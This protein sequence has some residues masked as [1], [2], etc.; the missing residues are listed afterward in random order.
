MSSTSSSRCSRRRACPSRRRRRSRA[1]PVQ[2]RREALAVV[3]SER[4][5]QRPVLL[6]CRSPMRPPEEAML[7]ARERRGVT[8]TTTWVLAVCCTAQFMVIL[9]LSIVN[10]ALPSIQT[11]LGFTAPDL[12]WVVNAY[13]ITFAG[14]LMLGGRAADY[15]GQRRTFSAALLLFALASLA[16]GLAP[17]QATLVAARA[18]QGFAG[19]GMAAASLAIITSSFPPG[20][21]L[22]RAIGL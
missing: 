9:D 13:A 15:F 21:Q 17:D 18:V 2:P 16:G 3:S 20:P 4:R 6:T 8:S 12:Q 22:H 5:L 1:R 11:A 19:A 14:F 10:V 7:E